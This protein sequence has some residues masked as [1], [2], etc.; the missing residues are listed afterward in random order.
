MP[1]ATKRKK[2][3][4]S[5]LKTEVI[6]LFNTGISGKMEV[7]GNIRQKNTIARDRFSRMY[8]SCYI[9]WA[10]IKEQAGNEATILAADEA[11]KRG[12]K[13]KLDK[14]EHLQKAINE[15]QADI[16]RAISEEYIFED[17]VYTLQENI[18]TAQTK[19]Y[20]RKTIKE[21]YSELNKMEG[22]YAPAKTE[23]KIDAKD[24]VIDFRK[25]Q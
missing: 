5:Q 25:A 16:D 21:L 1:K 3:S 6:A 4:D 22:D 19:A 2:L 10:K 17:G 15:I 14:Q 24:L 20:L 8:K 7:F 11:A 9:E 23:V 18:M 13:S 12:L